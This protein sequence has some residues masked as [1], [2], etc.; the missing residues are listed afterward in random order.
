MSAFRAASQ[1]VVDF[2]EAAIAAQLALSESLAQRRGGKDDLE[3]FE[4]GA[5]RRPGEVPVGAGA[6]EPILQDDAV[7]HRNE[8]AEHREPAPEL[9]VLGEAKVGIVATDAARRFGA[10]AKCTAVDDDVLAQEMAERVRSPA[11]AW[12]DGVVLPS[13]ALSSSILMW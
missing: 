4:V 6:A 8:I 7:T 9:Q 12:A 1:C 11:T 2:R 3:S 10:D 13:A 5:K